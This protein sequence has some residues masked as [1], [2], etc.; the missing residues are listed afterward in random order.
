MTCTT[1]QVFCLFC[2]LFCSRQPKTSPIHS[3]CVPPLPSPVSGL[4]L[5]FE[6]S[7]HLLQHP[8]LHLYRHT[9]N[10]LNNSLALVIL[11][12][13]AYLRTLTHAVGNAI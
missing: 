8:P 13:V 2:L 1:L 7:H 11:F 9:G 3:P 12:A 6:G 10:S 5:S 4:L